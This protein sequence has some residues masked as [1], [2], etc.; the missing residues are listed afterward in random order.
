M[1]QK[2]KT[3]QQTTTTNNNK[4]QHSQRHIVKSGSN[5]GPSAICMHLSL[6]IKP[7][8]TVSSFS[9][10]LP[11]SSKHINKYYFKNTNYIM[12]YTLFFTLLF[13]T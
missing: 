10:I 5:L 8:T 3:N 11:E 1:V 4:K 7:G 2:P 12:L 13:F 6:K 9:Y